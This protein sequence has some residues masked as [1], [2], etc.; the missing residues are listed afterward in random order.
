MESETLRLAHFAYFLEASLAANLAFS[1]LEKFRDGKFLLS[2]V[3]RSYVSEPNAPSIPGSVIDDLDRQREESESAWRNRIVK[4]MAWFARWA[5]TAVAISYVLLI[6][7]GFDYSI[8]ISQLFDN[9]WI[10]NLPSLAWASTMVFILG[11]PVP[12]A[13]VWFVVDSKIHQSMVKSRDSHEN[14]VLAT[15][16]GLKKK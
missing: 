7:I 9:K 5:Y 6:V 12:V 8:S 10:P 3:K 4:T 14:R 11:G 2:S 13:L 16:S 1:L 15:I